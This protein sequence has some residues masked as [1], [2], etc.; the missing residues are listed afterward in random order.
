MKFKD[1]SMVGFYE[2]HHAIPGV[3]I[4]VTSKNS[5]HDARIKVSSIADKWSEDNFSVQV[6]TLKIHGKCKLDNKSKFQIMAWGH[7]NIEGLLQI[8]DEGPGASKDYFDMLKP[9]TKLST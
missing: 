8:W 4:L 5:S 9:L 3:F 6:R 2:K 7:L 1:V